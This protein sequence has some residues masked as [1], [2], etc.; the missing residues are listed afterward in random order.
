MW[1]EPHPLASVY[2]RWVRSCFGHVGEPGV[3]KTRRGL[4]VQAVVHAV[5]QDRPT[6]TDGRHRLTGLVEAS[7]GASFMPPIGYLRCCVLL[8]PSPTRRHREKVR[9]GGSTWIP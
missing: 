9:V 6:A 7:S 2:L 3:R 5:G 8:E 4:D 1:K